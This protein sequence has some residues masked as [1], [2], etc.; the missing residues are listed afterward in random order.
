MTAVTPE[1]SAQR[2]A[3]YGK[4]RGVVASNVDPLGIGRLMVAVSDVLGDDSCMW[5][6]P[7]VPAAGAGM[8]SYAV[9]P[10]NAS[11]W[12]EFER[13]DPDYPVWV[14]CWVATPDDLPTQSQLTTPPVETLALVTTGG[15]AV[16]VSDRAGNDGGII[17]RSPGGTSLIVND[18]GI[19]LDNGQGASIVLSGNT[20]N[21]SQGALTVT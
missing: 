4:Y 3:Y 13:G 18:T 15:N 12:V 11:V 6:L 19:Y 17:L 14:G 8:G 1:K 5:A 16:A 20:V 10:V 9:P 2:A 21:V 7:A